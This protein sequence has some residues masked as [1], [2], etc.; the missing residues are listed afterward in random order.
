MKE[1]WRVTF[2]NKAAEEE[3]LNLSADLK[4][5]FIHVTD[6]LLN[7][8]PHNVGL[9]HIRPLGNKL[10]KLRLKGKDNIARSIFVLAT[11]RRIV[12]VHTFIKKTEKTP[13]RALNLAKR[14]LNE[15]S[16]D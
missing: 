11:K 6:L 10:W 13:S 4:A 9:P 12:I 5:K 2:V 16:D 14:R 1:T 15:V 7:F 3:I 8:G